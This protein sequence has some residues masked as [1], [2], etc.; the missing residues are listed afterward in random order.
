MDL[1]LLNTDEVLSIHERVRKDFETGDDPVGGDGVREGGHLLESAV[2]RQAVGFGNVLKHSD[3]LS[4]AA[5]LTFGLCCN[6][7]FHNGNKRTALVAMLAHLDKNGLTITGVNQKDLYAMIK[8]VATHSLGLR[9]DP[10]RKRKAYAYTKRDADE[11]VAEIAKWLNARSRKIERGERQ[12][13]FRQ[14]RRLLQNRGLGVKSMKSG[15]AAIYRT[16]TVRKGV[17]RKRVE[18]DKRVTIIGWP[19]DGQVIGIRE[20][21]RVRRV[22]Q[23]DEEHGCDTSSFYDG[24]DVIETFINEYRNVLRKLAK[25]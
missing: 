24:A 14:L 12:I 16:E 5:T 2:S 8:S 17:L 15:K 3:P 20:L 7:P 25:E 13:T 1:Q 22:L 9:I 10:K 4:N 18:V 21:K 11:E 23:L 19:N 6:H